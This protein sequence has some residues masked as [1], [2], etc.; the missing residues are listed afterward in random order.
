MLFR[1][2]CAA[3]QKKIG[4]EGFEPTIKIILSE[5]YDNMWIKIQHNGVGLTSEEQM[6]LFE[7]FFSNTQPAEDFDTGEHL[8]FSYY[9]I[10]EQHQGHM[11][12]TSDPDVGSTFHMQIPITR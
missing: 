11:A 8:S 7:P 6:S 10:T 12:V 1:H 9:I 3:L 2:A 4:T 5:S